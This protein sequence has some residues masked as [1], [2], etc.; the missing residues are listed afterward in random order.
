VCCILNYQCCLVL[1]VLCLDII[2]WPNLSICNK[3]FL[4][5]CISYRCVLG[6]VLC[7]P[8]SSNLCGRH[9]PFVV[10]LGDGSESSMFEG[11]PK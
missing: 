5:R 11:N 8:C 6:G 10:W 4:S 2:L 3:V 9:I 1:G 7:C